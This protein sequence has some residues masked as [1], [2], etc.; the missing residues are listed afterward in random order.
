MTIHWVTLLLMMGY[1]YLP[2]LFLKVVISGIWR[3]EFAL[4]DG[5][6][7]VELSRWELNRYRTRLRQRLLVRN[8]R[9]FSVFVYSVVI[10]IDLMR[11]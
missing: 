2:L 7:E 5:N 10:L 4:L 3:C 8:R 11:H 1:C 6:G 9:F